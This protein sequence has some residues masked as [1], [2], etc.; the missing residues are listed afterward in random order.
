MYIISGNIKELIIV[1]LQLASV[2][3]GHA[4]IIVSL[5]SKFLYDFDNDKQIYANRKFK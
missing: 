4:V 5:I 2:L 1:V 3:S